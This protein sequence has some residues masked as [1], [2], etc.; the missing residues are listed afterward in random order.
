MVDGRRLARRAARARKGVF[1]TTSTFSASSDLVLPALR[2][3]VYL[4]EA[5]TVEGDHT[6]DAT[7]A[8]S[9]NALRI[10]RGRAAA[11][12]VK[13]IQHDDL[14][15]LRRAQ[16]LDRIC[17]RISALRGDRQQVRTPSTGAS[18]GAIM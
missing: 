15:E 18:S 10:V 8:G 16:T 5:E 3:H 12:R 14:E 7:I 2:M 1:I 11:D 4:F 17:Y 6:I 9:A 13:H